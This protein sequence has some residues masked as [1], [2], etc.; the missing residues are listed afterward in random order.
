MDSGADA[1]SDEDTK[2]LLAGMAASI[3]L[4]CPKAGSREIPPPRI[5]K[6][7]RSVIQTFGPKGTGVLTRPDGPAL[8]SHK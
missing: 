4:K 5:S 1:Q 7:C 6:T 3:G 2:A 8:T